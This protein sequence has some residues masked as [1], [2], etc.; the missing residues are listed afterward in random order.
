LRKD[1]TRLKGIPQMQPLNTKLSDL[2]K[3]LSQIEATRKLYVKKKVWV[4]LLD[5]E[6]WEADRQA[7]IQKHGGEENINFVRFQ[8]VD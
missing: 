2:R 6:T 5:E 3:R 1:L 8:W 7:A 4:A